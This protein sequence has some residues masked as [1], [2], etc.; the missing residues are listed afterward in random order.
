MG[1]KCTN[2]VIFCA[3]WISIQNS[4][5]AVAAELAQKDNDTLYLLYVFNLHLA[6]EP[7]LSSGECRPQK[8]ND[9]NAARAKRPYSW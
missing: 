8:L 4:L 3:R 1:S 9:C 6:P 7:E 5:A 2:S